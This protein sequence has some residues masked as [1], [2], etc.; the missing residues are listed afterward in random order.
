MCVWLAALQINDS[1]GSF[2]PFTLRMYDNPLFLSPSFFLYLFL[3]RLTSNYLSV[4]LLLLLQY[5]S[6][7]YL[8]IFIFLYFFSIPFKLCIT[9]W[10]LVWCAFL[11]CPSFS[12]FH[13]CAG[14]VRSHFHLLLCSF[15]GKFL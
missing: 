12:L 9:T 2:F 7:S 10:C 11:F 6:L 1:V 4:P 3:S 8:F 14:C 15:R 5:T 13:A